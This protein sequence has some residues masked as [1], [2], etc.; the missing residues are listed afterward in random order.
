MRDWRDG[1]ERW[2]NNV[3]GDTVF[4]TEGQLL[5]KRVVVD[6]TSR[7]YGS[8]F[9]MLNGEAIILGSY[10]FG[11]PTFVRQVINSRILIGESLSTISVVYTLFLL[12]T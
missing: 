6:E 2:E 3:I 11:D 9:T 7:A 12:Y 1:E 8:C 5:T 4:N 10:S